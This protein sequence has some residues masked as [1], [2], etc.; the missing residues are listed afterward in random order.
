MGLNTKL[1][2]SVFV[3]GLLTVLSTGVVLYSQHQVSAE[4][5][6]I[7]D[8]NFPK[9]KLL[10]EMIAKFREIRI[11]VRSMPLIGNSPEDVK[12][13]VKDSILAV[14]DFLKSKEELEKFNFDEKGVE[15]LKRI[16]LAWTEFFT[17]GGGLLKL[18]ESGRPEDF[19]QMATEVKDICP[20]K[21]AKVIVEIKEFL[22]HQ[23]VRFQTVLKEAKDEQWE[24]LLISSAS[25]ALLFLLILGAGYAF[26]KSLS[27]RLERLTAELKESAFQIRS[28]EENLSQSSNRLSSSTDKNLSALQRTS[29][30]TTEISATLQKDAELVSKSQSLTSDTVREVQ[31]GKSLMGKMRE[32]VT[33]IDKSRKVMEGHIRKQDEDLKKIADLFVEIDSK[34]NVIN[35]IVF[36]TKLLAFNASVE[37]ARAGEN[38]KGFSVVA[39]EIGNLASMSGEAAKEISLLLKNSKDQVSDIVETTKVNFDES[40]ERTSG[41][42]SIC[43]KRTEECELSFESILKNV[44][45]LKGMTDQ[46]SR[47][48]LE[49]KSGVEEIDKAMQLLEADFRSNVDISQS[50][51]ESRNKLGAEASQLGQIAN[52]LSQFVFGQTTGHSHSEADQGQAELDQEREW[53]RAA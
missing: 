18:V 43:F 14:E 11:H 45:F 30:A 23:D 9:V 3:I 25:A 29:A 44:D 10:N 8:D 35:E 32:S 48:A 53:K 26:S 21:A 4:Y 47:S 42:V 33:E 46:I 19:Q 31:S 22:K 2:V 1:F 28:G 38:G 50:V 39:E 16:N 20:V 27:K 41:N 51:M 17:F 24:S 6:K 15:S 5:Q 49:Q 52:Q 40:L 34:T 13:H 37:A 36:Q 7:A 12:R